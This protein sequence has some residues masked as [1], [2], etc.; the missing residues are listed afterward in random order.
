MVNNLLPTTEI[1]TNRRFLKR[2]SVTP[3]EVVEH[4]LQQAAL[5]VCDLNGL[6]SSAFAKLGAAAWG[7]PGPRAAHTDAKAAKVSLDSLCRCVA[8]A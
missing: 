2:Q 7:E 6:K 5:G 8:F 1:V 3:L 4:I